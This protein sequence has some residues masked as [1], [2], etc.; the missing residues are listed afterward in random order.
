MKGTILL[1]RIFAVLTMAGVL[2]AVA[3]VPAMA[4]WANCGST[5]RVCTYADTFG[6]GADYYYTGPVNT[7]INIGPLW[8]DRISSY[9]NRFTHYWARM[10]QN[11]GC[12]GYNWELP[13]GGTYDQMPPFANDS[14]SSLKMVP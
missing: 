13:P 4:S 8:N 9:R 12:S 7:C 14:A 3:A 10:Y 11:A 6:N 5:E 2:V 1:R